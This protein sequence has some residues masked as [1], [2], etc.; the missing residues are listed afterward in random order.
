MKDFCLK[1]LLGATSIPFWAWIGCVTLVVMQLSGFG[2]R[3]V[4]IDQQHASEEMAEIG[5]AER[6]FDCERNQATDLAEYKELFMDKKY[7]EAANLIS[8]CAAILGGE[9]LSLLKQAEFLQIKG[10]LDDPTS[11]DKLKLRS[12][13]SLQDKYPDLAKPY[14]QRIEKLRFS[15]EKSDAKEAATMAKME[16]VRKKSEGAR[17]GMTKG[18]V[19]ASSWG[20]PSSVNTTIN[21]SGSREQWVYG[22][23]YYLYFTNGVLES[24]QTNN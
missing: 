23:G 20:K 21:A 2:L 17:I 24:I 19:L 3:S 13:E 4:G 1:V 6:K 9:K 11:S 10:V 5:R 14:I 7:K 12:I 8:V 15:V 16:A 18:D 22:D